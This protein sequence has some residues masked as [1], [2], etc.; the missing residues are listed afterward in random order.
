MFCEAKTPAT[1]PRAQ[2]RCYRDGRDEIHESIA[3]GSARSEGARN[4]HEVVQPLEATVVELFE[5]RTLS[6]IVREIA[7]HQGSDILLLFMWAAG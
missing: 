5:Q 6:Q 4:V 3:V 1:V 2:E 7:D